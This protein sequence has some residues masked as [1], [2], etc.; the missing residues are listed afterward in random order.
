M[1]AIRLLAILA[2]C[3]AD[4]AATSHLIYAS[5]PAN[6]AGMIA[7]IIVTNAVCLGFARLVVSSYNEKADHYAFSRSR[8]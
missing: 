6:T 3:L 2:L 8:R 5:S 4:V 7:A 1:Q